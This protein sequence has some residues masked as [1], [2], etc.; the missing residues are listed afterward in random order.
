MEQ[1]IDRFPE[2]SDNFEAQVRLAYRELGWLAD[3]DRLVRMDAYVRDFP[4]V[5]AALNRQIRFEAHLS[6][7]DPPIGT[8]L[9]N[10][11]ARA[12][13]GRIADP[14]PKTVADRSN[15]SLTEPDGGSL[16]QTAG[17]PHFAPLQVP[18]SIGRYTIEHLVGRGGMGMVFAAHDQVLD[19]R[20]AVKVA[21]PDGRR[22]ETLRVRLVGEARIAAKLHHENLAE[23]LDASASE[24][25]TYFVT[26]WAG[27]GSLYDL[28]EDP[29]APL[30]TDAALWLIQQIL[31]GLA[32]CHRQGV[33]HLDL[34][35]ANVLFDSDLG[36]EE[37]KA[38]GL[39]GI[40]L[41]ADFGLACRF[42]DSPG[43]TRAGTLAGTPLYMSPEQVHGQREDVGPWS[44]V[45]AA[46]LL[47]AELLTGRNPRRGDSM[48]DHIATVRPT[49]LWKDIRLHNVP[50]PVWRLLFR[51]LQPDRKLR[52]RDAGA[53][54]EDVVRVRE[55]RP[56]KSDSNHLWP[57]FVGWCRPPERITEAAIVSIATNVITIMAFIA[58]GLPHNLAS[59]IY[60]GFSRGEFL[61]DASKLILFPHLPMIVVGW[62]ILRGRRRLHVVNL[63][64]AVSL[65]VLVS[66]SLVT[67]QSPIRA[68]TGHPFALLA[69]HN[70]VFTMGLVMTTIHAMALP[71]WAAARG[72]IAAKQASSNLGSRT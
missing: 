3:N 61:I 4:K 9:R 1:L 72:H 49:D 26:R 69:T 16:E 35:P 57:R 22:G 40:P 31:A 43:L 51:A 24:A 39:P 13:P 36:C 46:G 71:A 66:G 58:V 59:G 7:V 29:A 47:F 52:Y 37:A 5:A 54:L 19:R 10:V 62:W 65:L 33:L 67:G 8:A 53:F 20:V 32:H 44:D 55:G 27:G 12:D 21:R 23:V 17:E 60:D 56:L 25:G 28:M 30:G 68:Y 6:Q 64:L 45:Y 2:I 41:V 50:K 48:A 42:D 63:L 38:F 14:S 34:K 15:R 18:D 70:I 11:E